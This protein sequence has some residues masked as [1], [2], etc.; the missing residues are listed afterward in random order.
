MDLM[1]PV[2]SPAAAAYPGHLYIHDLSPFIIQ[3]TEKIGLRWYGMAYLAG[4]AWGFWMMRRWCRAGRAPLAVDEIQDFVLSGG[5]GMIIGGR[6]G[7]CL[8]YAWP[9]MLH[10]PL[11]IFRLTD[12]GM[13]SHGGM[14]GLGAGALW[15]A[16]RRKRSVPVLVDILCATGPMGVALGRIANFINGELWGREAFT[17]P[18]A[19]IFPASVDASSL[20][21]A[22]LD[23][24]ANDQWMVEHA[25]E[26]RAWQ[27][28]HAVPRHPSQ[29][30]AMFLE[31]FLLLLILVP[32]H[33]RHRKPGLTTGLFCMLY[34]IARYCDE[35]FREPDAGYALFFG[36]MSKGQL[37][38]IPF[39]V[40][41]VIIF[42]WAARRPARPELYLPPAPPPAASG[43]QPA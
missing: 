3:F 36:W 15:F 21:P 14:L 31:G 24:A 27:I 23:R 8:L 28:A 6:L 12:G 19:V 25:G 7:Y 30:Y 41:G 2:L 5:L 16:W 39:F 33:A 17:A 13:A 1:N 29:L 10:D 4:L 40:I 35:F 18:L 32:F 11:F 37:Y 22:G 26:V 43:P 42:A 34:A 9:Q 20:A 38:S